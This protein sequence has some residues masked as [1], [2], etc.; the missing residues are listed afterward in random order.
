MSYDGGGAWTAPSTYSGPDKQPVR[1]FLGPRDPHVLVREGTGTVTWDLWRRC[2]RDQAS[3]S[4]GRPAAPPDRE[5]AA[6][7]QIITCSPT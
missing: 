5:Q 1:R 3:A 4:A 7:L 6:D 2:D